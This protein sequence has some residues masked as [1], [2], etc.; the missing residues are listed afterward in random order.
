ME[1]GND[2]KI[3]ENEQKY[4]SIQITRSKRQHRAKFYT[5]KIPGHEIIIRI[6]KKMMLQKMKYEKRKTLK[7]GSC[8]IHSNF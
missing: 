2:T 6:K 7:F 3:N 1:N 4:I 5:N 8:D